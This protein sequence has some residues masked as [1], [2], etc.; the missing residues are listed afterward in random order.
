MVCARQTR[1]NN[2]TYFK[3]ILQFVDH[4]AWVWRT[5]AKLSKPHTDEEPHDANVCYSVYVTNRRVRKITVKK[6]HI[7]T[8]QSKTFQRIMYYRV[9][10]SFECVG[11]AVIEKKNVFSHSRRRR[12]KIRRSNEHYG[13]CSW[14]QQTTHCISRFILLK[15]Y[16]CLDQFVVILWML[17]KANDCKERTKTF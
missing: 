10:F 5:Y 15:R 1:H 13:L 6:R 12:P 9:I 2:S 11:T 7:H 4:W 14:P 16:D 3:S 17:K 8:H